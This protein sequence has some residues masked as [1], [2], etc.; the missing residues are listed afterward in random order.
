MESERP[1]DIVTVIKEVVTRCVANAPSDRELFHV[2][3]E[4]IGDLKCLEADAGALE[5]KR[6]EYEILVYN[7][8][9]LE[10]YM[11]QLAVLREA[12]VTSAPEVVE[13]LTIDRK[14][15]VLITRYA[16]CPGE[17]LLSV[18]GMWVTFAKEAQQRFHRDMQV[19][20]ERGL[21]HPYAPR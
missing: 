6:N 11:D 2:V 19:L 12:G 16:A 18:K 7:L 1:I 14:F 20:I 9:R 21:I 15:G 10:S 5:F 4:A 17:K 8:A 3:S 13:L